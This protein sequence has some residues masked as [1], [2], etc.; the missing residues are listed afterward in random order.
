[1][2][3]ETTAAEVRLREI[4]SAFGEIVGT[5][6]SR[7]PDGRE[8]AWAVHV[9][10]AAAVELTDGVDEVA[11]EV[12][13]VLGTGTAGT[14]V[15]LRLVASP[16]AAMQIVRSLCHR[17]ARLAAGMLPWLTPEDV[18]LVPVLA[19]PSAYLLV[20]PGA[21][22][23]EEAPD[24]LVVAVGL[25]WAETLR[26]LDELHAAVIARDGLSTPVIARFNAA[27]MRTT[28]MSMVGVLRRLTDER[29]VSAAGHGLSH[30]IARGAGPALL[31]PLV[32]VLRDAT[33]SVQARETAAHLLDEAGAIE[34]VLELVL[35]P[36]TRAIAMA[37]FRLRVVESVAAM[38][39]DAPLADATEV[40]LP[41]GFR[42]DSEERI[43]DLEQAVELDP[44]AWV[45]WLLDRVP[46]RD[47]TA[48]PRT[49][50][51]ETFVT[52][53]RAALR[54]QLDEN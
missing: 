36:A 3:A 17:E 35:T 9:A 19:R 18:D 44:D 23:M 7:L 24:E 47:T 48:D 31:R 54:R 45:G 14:V 5:S 6:T 53:I 21:L 37:A 22:A 34:P 2:A 10:D 29:A 32:E 20:A 15:L 50:L 52:P 12:V 33:A 11:P 49:Q 1:M 43:A 51:V 27:E 8:V 4:A 38:V 28:A 30:M 13:T 46:P 40:G 42:L 16:L 26:P 25:S 39:I 41:E